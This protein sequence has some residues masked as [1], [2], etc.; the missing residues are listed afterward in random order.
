MGGAGA[1]DRFHDSGRGRSSS[2]PTAMSASSVAPTD[3]LFLEHHTMIAWSQGFADEN[4]S[5]AQS[6]WS[7][8]SRTSLSHGHPPPVYQHRH[9][10]DPYT[11]ASPPLY[12]TPIRYF[13][14]IQCFLLRPG[15]PTHLWMRVLA[16]D[17][18]SCLPLHHFP[19]T[20]L[21]ASYEF[22]CSIK[23]TR[24]LEPEF[25]YQEDGHRATL[26]RGR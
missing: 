25:P 21:P 2:I 11:Y 4:D 12:L 13:T 17:F 1:E 7:R 14:R 9:R 5:R 18:R 26:H 15:E 6:G 22:H 8:P 24:R 23:P 10:T 16:I 20:P 3:R 19:Y